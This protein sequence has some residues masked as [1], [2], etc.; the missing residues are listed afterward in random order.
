MEKVLNIG[1]KEIKMKSSS[2]IIFVYRNNFNEDFMI[3]LIEMNN[4]MQNLGKEHEAEALDYEFFLKSAWCMNKLA[5]DTIPPFE[6]WLNQ[7]E[8]LELMQAIPE[9]IPILTGELQQINDKKK[10][11]QTITNK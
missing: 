8:L 5:D 1:G 7:F 6:E 3:K 11:E 4:K 10:L 2:A 9:V